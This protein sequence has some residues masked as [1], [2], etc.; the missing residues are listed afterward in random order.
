MSCCAILANVIGIAAASLIA[1]IVGVLAERR[2]RTGAKLFSGRLLSGIV[3][4]VMPVVVFF[5]VISLKL[6]AGVGAGLIYGWTERLTVL[7]LAWFI[8][9]KV[10][11]LSRPAIGALMACVVIA[12]TGYLGIPMTALL[13]GNH[14]IG[15]AVIYENLVNVPLVLLVGF[16]VGAAY[17]TRAGERPSDRVKSFFTRNPPLYALVLALLVPHTISPSWGPGLAHALALG[18]A[19]IGFFALGVNLMLEHEEE[20]VRLFPPPFTRPVA[21]AVMLRLVIAPAVMIGLSQLFTKAP[22]A[23]L[24]EAAMPAGINALVV[25]HLYGLDMRVTVGAIAWSTPVAVSAGV[26]IASLGGL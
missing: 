2:W 4:L 10:L 21:A 19:P 16:A 3:Y 15:M 17:G 26:L 20:G 8:G 18:I 9:T 7:G 23:F 25:S 14:Q 12:N 13:L 1:L 11:K 5:T 22:D 24:L 6:T